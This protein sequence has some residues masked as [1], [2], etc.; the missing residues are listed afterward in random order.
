MALDKTFAVGE[1]VSAADVN[2]H[3]LG[4]WTPID[5]RVISSGSPLA[6]V[7]FASLDTNFRT[8]RLTFDV[9]TAGSAFSLRLNNDTGTNYHYTL[10]QGDATTVTSSSTASATSIPIGFN[11]NTYT[12]GQ[13]IISKITAASQAR[14]TENA[15]RGEAG[16]VIRTCLLAGVWGNVAS[17]INRI[18]VFDSISTFYGMV[19]L[20]G[21]RGV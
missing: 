5:K 14:I 4:L 11:S 12:M 6:T 17:V 8:F 19:S 21:M 15:I 7:S 18:D 13:C 16:G 2:A 3:L 10:T 20:E 1:V 9:K